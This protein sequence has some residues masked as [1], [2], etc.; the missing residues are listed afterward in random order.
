MA[1]ERGCE[2]RLCAKQ[3]DWSQELQGPGAEA[4]EE[5]LWEAQKLRMGLVSLGISGGCEKKKE[6]GNEKKE[7]EKAGGRRHC[8]ETQ[9]MRHVQG[10]CG[11]M[12]Q[13][14]HLVRVPTAGPLALCPGLAGWGCKVP[15]EGLQTEAKRK[16]SKGLRS[17]PE[18]R[19]LTSE[20]L[21]V[22]VQSRVQPGN[23]Q[24]PAPQVGSFV[25]PCVTKTHMV[26]PTGTPLPPLSEAPAC[27]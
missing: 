24:P 23:L 19:G 6:R 15:S 21:E 25:F 27:P 1:K 3:Q 7:G 17:G 26:E 11:H 20:P 12:T 22:W 9:G 10:P 16:K 18:Q 13:W 8:L 14:P 2:E 5:W 4:G